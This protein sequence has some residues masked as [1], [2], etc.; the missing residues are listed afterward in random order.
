MALRFATLHHGGNDRDNPILEDQYLT[1]VLN[2]QD[3][4]QVLKLCVVMVGGSIFYDLTSLCVEDRE[5]IS[6]DVVAGV[7]LQAG[8]PPVKNVV[9]FTVTPHVMSKQVIYVASQPGAMI[10]LDGYNAEDITKPLIY[11]IYEQ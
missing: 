5:S 10:T 2:K 9:R 11:P 6:V 7:H 3:Y 1:I 4:D 8:Y